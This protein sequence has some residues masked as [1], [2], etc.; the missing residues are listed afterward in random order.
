MGCDGYLTEPRIPTWNVSCYECGGNILNNQDAEWHF[1]TC[2]NG[3]RLRVS[4]EE[5]G[6]E[7]R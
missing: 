6:Y 4:V 2:G 7:A 1:E 3:D 5:E